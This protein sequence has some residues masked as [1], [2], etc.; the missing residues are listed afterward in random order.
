SV[1]LELAVDD[2]LPSVDGRGA[3]L[4]ALFFALIARAARA[5]ASDPRRRDAR[6]RIRVA[7]DLAVASVRVAIE[8]DGP[9]IPPERCLA[10][11]ERRGDVEDLSS[12]EE[13]VRDIL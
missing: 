1:D 3:D 8:D 9:P 7:A 2:V 11:F 6:G 4:H 5:I 12:V 13:T 10:L